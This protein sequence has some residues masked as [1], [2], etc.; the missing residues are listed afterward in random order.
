MRLVLTTL[1]LADLDE[2]ERY[3][4]RDDPAAAI[5]TVLRLLA[6]AELLARH[7][8]AGRAGRVPGTRELVVTSTPY[9]M[10]YRVRDNMVEVLRVL[11][12]RRRGPTRF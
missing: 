10:P 2:F 4:A 1:A 3:I 7:P 5:D 8:E 6:A 12:G 11:H 9:V